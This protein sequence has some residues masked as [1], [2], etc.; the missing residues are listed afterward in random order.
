MSSLLLFRLNFFSIRAPCKN[1]L[2]QLNRSLLMMCWKPSLIR[3]LSSTSMCLSNC[4]LVNVG[5]PLRIKYYLWENGYDDIKHA[6]CVLFSTLSQWLFLIPCCTFCS[7]PLL[8]S[9][10]VPICTVNRFAESF[11]K[12]ISK[13]KLVTVSKKLKTKILQWCLH[14]F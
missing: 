4:K 10:T 11:T 9:T 14:M 6:R 7:N 3:S 2:F 1:L 5:S 13:T 8:P 12:I